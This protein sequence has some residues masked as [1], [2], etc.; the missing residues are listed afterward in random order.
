M[1]PKV[2]L[3]MGFP[4]TATPSPTSCSNTAAG[5]ALGSD[6]YARG[7]AFLRTYSDRSAI[8]VDSTAVSKESEDDLYNGWRL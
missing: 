6:I 2:V 7:L 8:S 5:N 1:S 4:P 3:P